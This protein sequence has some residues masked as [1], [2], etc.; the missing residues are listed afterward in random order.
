MTLVDLNVELSKRSRVAQE[1]FC[2]V[3]CY[4]SLCCVL[5]T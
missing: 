4:D 3:D 1:K 5:Q 2:K